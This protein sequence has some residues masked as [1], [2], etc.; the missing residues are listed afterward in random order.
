MKNDLKNK[1][2]NFGTKMYFKKIKGTSHLIAKKKLSDQNVL[3][4]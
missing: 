3:Y 2:I 1:K 4:K